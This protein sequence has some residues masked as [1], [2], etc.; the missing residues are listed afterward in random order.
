MCPSCIALV[1]TEVS[2]LIFVSVHRNTKSPSTDTATWRAS[3]GEFGYSIRFVWASAGS[4]SP[5][6]LAFQT[7]AAGNYQTWTPR[8]P[9]TVEHRAKVSLLL[10]AMVVPVGGIIRHD[11]WLLIAGTNSRSGT[12]V[13]HS[14][15][16][17]PNTYRPRNRQRADHVTDH[18]ASSSASTVL[19]SE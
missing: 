14:T 16:H 12:D 6:C 19:Q 13:H 11:C 8:L 15:D 1:C 3:K 17:V 7:A 4:S 5:L 18:I 9:A 2:L 10:L